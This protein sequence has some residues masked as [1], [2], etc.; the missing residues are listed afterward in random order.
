MK[1]ETYSP[2]L[3]PVA[4]LAVDLE[5]DAKGLKDEYAVLHEPRA[6]S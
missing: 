3:T 4:E 1:G 5:N 2:T 6:D